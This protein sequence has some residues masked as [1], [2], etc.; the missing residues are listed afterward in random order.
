MDCDDNKINFRLFDTVNLSSVHWTNCDYEEK[1]RK[2]AGVNS[3]QDKCIHATA[4]KDTNTQ[5]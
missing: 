2:C 1:E 4:Y 3:F 5:I